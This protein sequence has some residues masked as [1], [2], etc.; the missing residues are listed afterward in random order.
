MKKEAWDSPK[1]KRLCRRLKLPRWAGVGILES[2]WR[3]TAMNAPRGDIG[4][5]S[6]ADI[7]EGIDWRGEP[8]RLVDA[9][10]AEGWVDP[11][12][13]VRFVIHDWNEHAPDYVKKSLKRQGLTFICGGH[14]PDNGGHCPDNG[15]LPRLDIPRLDIPSDGGHRPP[16]DISDV[17]TAIF[18]R[19]PQYRRQTLPQVASALAE[20]VGRSTDPQK[21]LREIDRNHALWCQSEQFA[22]GFVPRLA[23]KW[24][25]EGEWMN[26]PP[27]QTTPPT[28]PEKPTLPIPLADYDAIAT[29]PAHRYRPWFDSLSDAE[30]A[31]NRADL[32]AW[33]RRQSAESG[34]H[35]TK[36]PVPIPRPT[37]PPDRRSTA[38]PAPKTG[39]LV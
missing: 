1:L 34:R 11:H 3:F 28:E 5:F 8:Y 35:A 38:T 27:G 15:G 10:R 7:A 2:V 12:P 14:C 20:I 37:A 39:G 6:D 21:T 25:A 24:L 22:R 33:E 4:R 32:A 31:R 26:P 18:L 9:L 30:H 16:V 19:H 17:A 36:G 23:T 29:D 13:T